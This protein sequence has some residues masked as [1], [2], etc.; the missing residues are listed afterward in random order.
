VGSTSEVDARVAGLLESMG[1]RVVRLPDGLTYKRGSL[2]G[3]LTAFTPKK[4]AA[5]VRVRAS[6]PSPLNVTFE[7][8]T[9][10]QVLTDAER[11][12]WAKE[13]RMV[14][15]A[16]ELRPVELLD[17]ND[18]AAVTLAKHTTLY[19]LGFPCWAASYLPCAGSDSTSSES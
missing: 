5:R 19:S 17:A 6:A 15:D 16:I 8:D 3:S 12:F 7:I 13:C 11:R 1:Y 4:W 9:T 18:A 10:G 14:V 2:F